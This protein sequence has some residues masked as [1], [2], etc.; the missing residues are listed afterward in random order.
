MN[1]FSLDTNSSIEWLEAGKILV[2]PTESI[3]GLGCDAFNQNAVDLI[4][5]IKKRNK[6]KSFILLIKSLESFQKYLENIKEIDKKYLSQF[7]PGPYTF[8]IRYNEKLPVHLKNNNG[9]IALRVSNHLPLKSLF[10]R[11]SGHIVSTSANISGS[12]NLNNPKQILDFFVS[13]EMAYYDEVLGV[14]KSPS[15]IIDLESR[16]IVRA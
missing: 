5:K 1:K 13:D 6:N 16:L 8:L 4:F 9:K 7:W 11:Y 12:A 3:W 14:N 10:D 15:T 2:H